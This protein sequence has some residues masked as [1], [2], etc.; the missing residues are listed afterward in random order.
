MANI[1]ITIQD[2][3]GKPIDKVTRSIVGS[4]WAPVE[5]TGGSDSFPALSPEMTM[6]FT[7]PGYSNVTQT[8]K[9]GENKVTMYKV[10][11]VGTL[12]KYKWLIGILLLIVAVYFAYKY[13]V[14]NK[15]KL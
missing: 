9:E 12:D 4:T 3:S 14:W 1:N 8:V 2:S 6:I 5:I 13:K 15:L 11:I 10:G 7:A